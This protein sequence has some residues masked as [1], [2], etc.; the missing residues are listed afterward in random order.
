MAQQAEPERRVNGDPFDLGL[1][2]SELERGG[3]FGLQD[4]FEFPLDTSTSTSTSKVN[5]GP[6]KGQRY[7]QKKK[8][9]TDWHSPI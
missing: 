5:D 9:S 6:S 4:G 3:T 8:V 2:L 1:D 7:R